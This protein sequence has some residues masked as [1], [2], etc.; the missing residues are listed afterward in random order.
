L[1][2]VGPDWKLWVQIGNCGS[3]LEIVG[4]DWKLWVQIGNCG[5]RLEIV[6]PDWIKMVYFDCL[7]SIVRTF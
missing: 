2:I 1:E 6:G 7:M 4:P 5:S 3:R